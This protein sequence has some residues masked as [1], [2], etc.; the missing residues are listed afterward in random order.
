MVRAWSSA[1]AHVTMRL[2]TLPPPPCL[3]LCDW[4]VCLRTPSLLLLPDVPHGRIWTDATWTWQM[5]QRGGQV[6]HPVTRP[7]T[8]T[9]AVPDPGGS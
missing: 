4:P 3:C 8:T 6:L 1:Y 2:V 7:Q 9:F 5:M